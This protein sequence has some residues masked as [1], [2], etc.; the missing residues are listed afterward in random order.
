MSKE[1]WQQ[2]EGYDNYQISSLGRVR[3]T[4]TG[5]ILKPRYRGGYTRVVLYDS[6]HKKK[7]YNIHYL[8]ASAYIP[9]PESKPHI[10]HKNGV[11]D[12]NSVDNLRW[13]TPIEN[14]RNPITSGKQREG[15]RGHTVSLE[16]RK[17]I[18]NANRGKH[19]SEETK[20]KLRLAGLGKVPW[21]KGAPMRKETLEKILSIKSERYAN[22]T[23]V[24]KN[25]KR[26]AQYSPKGELLGIWESARM[27]C[28][29]V[30]ITAPNLC[31][32]LK[33]EKPMKDGTIWRYYEER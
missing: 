30:G 25:R 11:R 29:D 28:A 31:W 1:R 7:Q 19:R 6:E 20:E 33:R 12:D 18:S 2:I 8:V 26:V 22:G 5:I 15:M 16:C 13:V 21:N 9:N 10:D 27:A 4:I 14:A 24:P 3:N 23:I 17:K 32:H